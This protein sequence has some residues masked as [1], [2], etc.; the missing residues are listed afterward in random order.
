[1]LAAAE[2]VF[3]VGPYRRRRVSFIADVTVRALVCAYSCWIEFWAFVRVRSRGFE[4]AGNGK[5]P[6]NGVKGPCTDSDDLFDHPARD[7]RGV[8]HVMAQWM[9][10]FTEA[11]DAGVDD[12]FS[13]GG[14][15]KDAMSYV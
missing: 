3:L 12:P 7:R 10:Y 4:M 13:R 1:M 14:C 8:P 9:G 15:F 2:D 11:L 6:L 5:G